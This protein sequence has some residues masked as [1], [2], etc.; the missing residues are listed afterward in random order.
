MTLGSERGSIIFVTDTTIYARYTVHTEM[1]IDLAVVYRK[2]SASARQLVSYSRDGIMKI[3]G[4]KAASFELLHSI[5]IGQQ[6]CL[7]RSLQKRLFVCM[8]S[9]EMRMF[10]LK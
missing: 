9:G 5:E 8:D 4:F 7:L 10:V 2:E 3:V 6:I 1:I